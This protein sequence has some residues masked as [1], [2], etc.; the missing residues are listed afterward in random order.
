MRLDPRINELL[1]EAQDQCDT[2]AGD[3]YCANA[4]WFGYEQYEGLGLKER[5]CDLV[6]WE[7]VSKQYMGVLGGHEAYDIAYAKIYDALPDC[8][9]GCGCMWG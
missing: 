4:I 3:Y 2:G 9:G 8:R 7:R 6:G 1:K 5:L